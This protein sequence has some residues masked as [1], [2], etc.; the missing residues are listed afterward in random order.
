MIDHSAGQMVCR[1]GAQWSHHAITAPVSV[2]ASFPQT[3][4]MVYPGVCTWANGSDDLE[5]VRGDIL[6]GCRLVADDDDDV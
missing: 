6:R 2:T 3:N 1:D 4:A 5:G